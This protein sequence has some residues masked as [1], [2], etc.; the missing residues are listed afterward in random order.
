MADPP[1]RGVASTS[2]TAPPENDPEVLNPF[3]FLALDGQNQV[4]QA[5]ASTVK[6]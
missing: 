4:P 3:H 2:A 1:G 5:A 6:V